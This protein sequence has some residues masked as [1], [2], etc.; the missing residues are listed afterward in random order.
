VLP[1]LTRLRPTTLLEDITVPGSKLPA[2]VEE[3]GKIAARYDVRVAVFGHA[4]HGNIHPTFLTDSK[5]SDEMA[6]VRSA[7]GEMMQACVDLEG[8]VSGEHGVGLDKKPYLKLEVGQ[9]G[10]EV[11]KSLK[12][13]LDPRGIMNP[14]KM[15]YED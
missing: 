2:M 12:D 1:A 13:S 5:D 4:G 9:A 3:I 10:Y 7:I 14:G 11:M 6:R 15:F 8:T